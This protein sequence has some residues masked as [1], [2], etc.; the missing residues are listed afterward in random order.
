MELNAVETRQVSV[1]VSDRDIL[2]AARRILIAR[3]KELRPFPDARINFG[4]EY[5]VAQHKWCDW[6]YQGIQPY[7]RHYGVIATEEQLVFDT[8][9]ADFEKYM[10][11]GNN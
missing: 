2:L 5:G 10:K 4:E 7:R 8:F 1:E 9:L 11:A 6:A 3:N